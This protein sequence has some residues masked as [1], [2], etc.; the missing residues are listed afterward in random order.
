MVS[1]RHEAAARGWG[2]SCCVGTLQCRPGFQQG[3]GMTAF[4]L[5]GCLVEE[6]LVLGHWELK[7]Q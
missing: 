6:G 3:T 5:G 4:A 1:A 7:A 2:D